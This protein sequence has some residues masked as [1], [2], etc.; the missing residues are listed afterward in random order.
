MSIKNKDLRFE[1]VFAVAPMMDWTDRHCRYFHRLM[2]SNTLLYTE[3]ITSAALIRGNAVHL[4]D[5]NIAEQPLALQLGGSDPQELSEAARLGEDRGYTE[6][7]L[8]IG[9]P[10]S[11]VKAGAFGAVLMEQPKLVAECITEMRKAVTID[12]T[13]KCRIGVDNQNPENTLPYFLSEIQEAGVNKV[14]IHAR[15]ALLDGLSPKQNRNIPPLDY[16]IVSRMKKQFDDLHI[17]INGG[18][19]TLA[20]AA[21]L[22]NK[23]FD[24]VMVGRA[25][26]NSPW[27][28]LS[29]V[30]KTIYN[31]TPKLI[32][33][34]DIIMRMIPYIKN[35]LMNGGKVHQV[36][37][38]M[39]GLFN[40][41]QNAR[42]WRQ[43][44]SQEGVMP[45]ADET[46]LL[47]AYENMVAVKEIETIADVA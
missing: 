6:V 5:H 26:Y 28:I 44:L 38:H 45:Y 34:F 36:T 35:H 11:R 23:G 2:T 31:D 3:M 8:N 18:I 33:R 17:S 47:K 42:K 15:K 24:G 13:V 10:S 19:S 41:E 14:T 43:T 21:S 1:K 16:E 27:E 4:L 22:I 20:S 37:R 30:D 12:I 25:V 46:I 9:C 7:N 40:G 39:L 32:T 29:N